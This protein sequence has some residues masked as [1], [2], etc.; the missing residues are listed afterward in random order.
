[1]KNLY[2]QNWPGSSPLP[3]FRHNPVFIFLFLHPFRHPFGGAAKQAEILGTAKRVEMADVEQMKKI[4]PTHHVWDCLLSKCLQAGVLVS[5]YRIGI[6]GSK[7]ILSNNQSR[8]TLWVLDTC[9]IVGIPAFD[10]HLNHG[11]IVLKHVQHSNG[12]R[13][14]H[15]RKHIVNMKQI[16]TVVRVWSF[17]LI[18]RTFAWRDVMQQ[19][20]L[21]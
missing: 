21:C 3:W 2:E 18:L 9:R 15:I 8:A 20:S 5:M 17:C 4:I 13:K 1:M 7:L 14:S 12:L 11:F 19:V 6:L 16:R 10:Y